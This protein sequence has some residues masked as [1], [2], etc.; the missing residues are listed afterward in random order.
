MN[1]INTSQLQQ[2]LTIGKEVL[3]EVEVDSVLERSMDHLVEVSGAERG[4]IILFNNKGDRHYQTARN[5]EKQD[6]DHPEFEIS[7]TIIEQV[8]SNG[9]PVYLKNALEEKSLDKSKSVRRLKIL[10]VICLPLIFDE[11]I[12]GVIYLDNRTAL[13]RFTSETSELIKSFADFISLAA[14]HAMER[15]HWKKKQTALEEELRFQYNFE[16]IIGQSPK[17]IKVLEMISQVADTDATVLIEGESGT[18][19]E[20]TVN[21]LHYNSSRRDKS[22]LSVN[23]AAFPENLLES[24][25]FGHEKGSFTGAYKHQ[26]GKFELADNGTLFLDEVDEMSPALQAKLLRV[27][28]FGEFAPIGSEETKQCDVRIIAASKSD[29][30]KLVEDGKFR[31]DL[32]YRLNLFIIKLPALRERLGDILPLAE[33]FLI[34][35]C[36]RL[37]KEGLKFNPQTKQFLQNYNYPGNVRELENIIHRAAIV[38]KT[39][40]I[41]PEHLPEEVTSGKF[42]KSVSSYQSLSFKDAKEKVISD[43][44]HQYLVQILEECNGVISKAAERMGMHK[45]N[46]HEKLNKYGIRPDK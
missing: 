36:K 11:K 4:I 3:A 25:F 23:C 39:K 30:K 21:A 17:M 42:N 24:E 2:L 28:Q 14:Y 43:F 44:E 9:E 13:G 26:K 20:L 5:L 6:I 10:S 33:Y 8:N 12:F 18:G 27:I 40:L 45:K 34:D 16:T 19:K 29:L 31:E 15:N 41:K 46:L 7:Q 1:T 37:N 38:C 32:Y 35:A 22:L